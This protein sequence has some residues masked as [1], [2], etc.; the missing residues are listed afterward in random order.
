MGKLSLNLV[1][2]EPLTFAQE[3]DNFVNPIQLNLLLASVL[4]LLD[5]DLISC[6]MF[7][8]F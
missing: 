2:G 4:D 1:P 3:L 7:H 8:E 5:H 6:G